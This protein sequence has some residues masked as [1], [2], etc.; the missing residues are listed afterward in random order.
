MPVSVTLTD[1]LI[2]P[3]LFTLSGSRMM[4]WWE[5]VGLLIG[6]MVSIGGVTGT[7]SEPTLMVLGCALVVTFSMVGG[8]HSGTFVCATQ[9]ATPSTQTLFRVPSTS[10]DRSPS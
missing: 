9:T 3:L 8:T 4:L 6:R 1:G 2:L 7:W 5:Q 10:Q